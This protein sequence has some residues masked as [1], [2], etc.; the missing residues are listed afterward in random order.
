MQVQFCIKVWMHL[1]Y[2]IHMPQ[3]ISFWYY[4]WLQLGSLSFR[5]ASVING[6]IASSLKL[7]VLIISFLHISVFHAAWI[8][9]VHS[10]QCFHLDTAH[11]LER[12]AHAY[13]FVEYCEQSLRVL[14]TLCKFHAHR[15]IFPTSL[16]SNEDIKNLIN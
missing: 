10:R 8:F 3:D 2:H 16:E 14:P 12:E 6:K 7:F 1:V 5:G 11:V 9:Q 4:S 13:V 15:L